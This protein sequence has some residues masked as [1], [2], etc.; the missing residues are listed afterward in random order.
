MLDEQFSE[1]KLEI[2]AAAQNIIFT[3]NTTKISLTDVAQELG[4]THNALYRHFK[5]KDDLWYSLAKYWLFENEQVLQHLIDDATTNALQTLNDWLTTLTSSKR[6][7]Y[8]EHPALF[9]LYT[10]LVQN[11]PDLEQEHLLNLRQ[12]ILAIFNIQN[13]Q[14]VQIEHAQAILDVFVYF[15]DPRF[16][17]FWQD[18]NIQKRQENISQLIAPQI[19]FN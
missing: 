1:R 8:A 10:D 11:H 19:H 18:A 3:K 6:E 5:N 13:A 4:I 14:D 17:D 2:L 12:Q 9:D 15:Y 7:T 16:K